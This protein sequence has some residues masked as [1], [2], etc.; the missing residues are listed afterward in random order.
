MVAR[1]AL[2]ERLLAASAGAVVCVV[3]PPGYGKTTLLAQW[4]QRKGDRV[5]WVTVDQYDNDPSVLL[6]YLAV[7]L[8]R[9]ASVDLDTFQV[10]AS[11]V[12][13]VPPTV[14]PR[15]AAAMSAAT[16]PVDLVLDQVELLHNRQCLDALEQLAA[17]LSGGCQLA[18]ASRTR[19][20]LPLGL[21]RTQDRLVEVGAADLA[22]DRREA[23]A[24]LEGAEVRL[25]AEHA[26]EC[27]A[28]PRGGR[29]GCTW[30][31]WRY[32]LAVRAWAPGML[33]WRL[34]GTTGSS[35]TT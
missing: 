33:K 30:R 23:W 16:E 25:A 29:R 20:R 1:T 5:G 15:L 7:A 13:H 4:A 9:V 10:L 21:L 14:V 32:G 8:G 22:M 28:G 11:P 19:P 24:L 12:T 35:S 27:T 6:T 34:P 18:M 3:A 17:Q 31:P 2:V 26:A